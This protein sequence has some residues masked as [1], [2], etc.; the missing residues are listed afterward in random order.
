M[1]I[2]TDDELTP[3][4]AMLT[5]EQAVRLE[6]LIASIRAM[7][8][9]IDDNDVVDALLD[10]GLTAFESISDLLEPFA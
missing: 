10:T 3:V 6:V 4:T 2:T 9:A 5:Q 7:N 8:P 1:T